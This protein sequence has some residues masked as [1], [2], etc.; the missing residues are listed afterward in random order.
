M[1]RST[2]ILVCISLLFAISSVAPA[3]AEIQT[4]TSKPTVE[5]LAPG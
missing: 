4:V 2:L 5:S 3:S 1:T